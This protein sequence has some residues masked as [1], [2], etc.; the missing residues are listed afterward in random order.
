MRPAVD[1]VIAM[2]TVAR[3]S[4]IVRRF[5]SYPHVCGGVNA[6]KTDVILL[7][8]CASLGSTL[9]L[10]SSNIKMAVRRIPVVVFQI[11]ERE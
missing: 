2:C 4:L 3:T 7:M 10:S 5:E 11:F 1:L 8:K 9:L 6:R